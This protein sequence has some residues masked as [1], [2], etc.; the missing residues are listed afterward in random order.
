MESAVN[1]FAYYCARSLIYLRGVLSEEVVDHLSLAC[2]SRSPEIS[3]WA[4][5]AKKSAYFGLPMRKR[6]AKF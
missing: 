5:S 1:E 3:L 2:N 6:R 4:V